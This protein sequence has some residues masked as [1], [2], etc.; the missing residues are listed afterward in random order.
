MCLASYPSRKLFTVLF[1]E[2][3]LLFRAD[4]SCSQSRG[5]LRH[6][7]QANK[8]L[9]YGLKL[10]NLRNEVGGGVAKW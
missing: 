6:Y 2:P 10:F 7:H 5:S 4:S 9:A 3:K 8:L 1:S